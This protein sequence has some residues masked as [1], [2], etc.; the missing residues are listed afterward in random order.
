MGKKPE[1]AFHIGATEA[2]H[3]ANIVTGTFLLNNLYASVLFDIGADK[4]FISLEFASLLSL[5]TV[6]LETPYVIELAKGKLIKSN[7]VIQECSL[8]LNDHLFN[9][10]LLPIELEALMS[11]S[12]CLRKGCQAFLSHVMEN[13]SLQ[14]CIEDIPVVRYFPEVFP[15]D[16]SGLPP[17]RQVEFRIDLIPGAAPVAKAPYRLAPSEMQEPSATYFSKI[18]LRSGYHQ[19]RIHDD[20]VPKTS[21]RTRY[22]HYEFLATPFGLTN[23]PAVF[24]NLM[25]RKNQPFIW[26]SQQE[27]ALQLLKH[28]LRKAPIFALPEG[29][30]NFTVYCDASRQGLGCVS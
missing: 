8:N 2:R 6:D 30:N 26:G 3:D 12:K 10:N 15:E 9:I 28:K 7:S 24:M 14:K 20:D 18:N 22:G 13:C 19:L 25:N 27:E 29:T 16:I 17:V 23:A 5:H 1:G 4:S 21:F 11:L